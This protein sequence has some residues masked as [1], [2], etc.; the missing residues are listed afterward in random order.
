MSEPEPEPVEEI[1]EEKAKLYV[2]DPE[3]YQKTK[4]LEAIHEARKA[5]QETRRNRV[6]DV[7]KYSE[8][9]SDWLEV[10]ANILSEK[11]AHYGEEL[12]PLI[13]EGLEKGILS[14]EDI[15]VDIPTEDEPYHL[16]RFIEFDG[17]FVG[18]TPVEKSRPLEINAYFRQLNRIR[19]KLGFG[20]DIEENKGPAEV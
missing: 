20:L 15:Q 13:E 11:V 18:D 16:I 9:R 6:D 3:D 4:K 19:R 1:E 10:Y 7:E 14:E 17:K 8:F 2:A 5:V 12:L